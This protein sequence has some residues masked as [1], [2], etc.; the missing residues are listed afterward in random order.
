MWQRSH[1]APYCAQ[2][3]VIL[4][5]AA[6]HCCDI[7]T[8]PGRL[9]M[10]G[11]ALQFAVRARAAES[12]PPWRDR[13]PTAAS[14][15]A[16]GSRRI[17]CR[18]RPCARHRARGNRCRPRR[19]PPKARVAWHC[20]QL[21]TRCSPSRGIIGQVVIEDDRRWPRS[22][23]RD[24]HSQPPL[25]LPPCGSSLRWHPRAVLGE[26]LGGRRRGVAGVAV[27]LGVR[28]HQREL[29]FAPRD[30]RSPAA[31]A[32]CRDSPRTWRRKRAA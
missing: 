18:G 15:S 2:V 1:C 10:A 16:S 3:P 13:T 32:R 22:S 24:R 6:P 20:A 28:P 9:A 8:V 31:S 7:F 17:S 12:A 30:R 5:M 11:G 27:D 26:L 25:S 21:T 14:R 19:R 23:G 4:V 29:V